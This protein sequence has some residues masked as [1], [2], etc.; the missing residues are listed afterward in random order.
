MRQTEVGATL[1]EA[2]NQ[3]SAMMAASQKQTL[4]IVQQ[5]ITGRAHQGAQGLVARGADA[6]T[7][8]LETIYNWEDHHPAPSET[9]VMRPGRHYQQEGP[10]KAESWG[11][12]QRFMRVPQTDP[13]RDRWD[14][15]CLGPWQHEFHQGP[16]DRA[17]CLGPSQGTQQM[18]SFGGLVR[19][20]PGMLPKPPQAMRQTEVGATLQEALNQMSAMMAASQKQTLDIVQQMITGRAH[21]GAQGLVARGAD[22]QTKGL[23]TIYNWEDHHPAPSETRVMRPG[24]HYQQ[25]GPP[26]AESWGESQRFMRVPQT[27]PARDRWDD[28]CLGPWQHEFHQGPADRA[29]CLGPSQGMQQMTSFGRLVRDKPGMLPRPTLVWCLVLYW[30]MTMDCHTSLGPTKDI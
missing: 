17:A 19:D 4:D 26:K 8:G 12:S 7:K 10:P 2:L 1:Q 21:Q 15:Q 11:E 24:R 6:Q 27:D 13:A 30:D 9:R 14:D 29:A 20:K 16:A 18:T 23:E 22:A 25:E 3:M 5:M 28:Q